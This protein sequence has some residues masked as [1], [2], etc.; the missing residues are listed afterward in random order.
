MGWPS[1]EDASG[2]RSSDGLW[3][4]LVFFFLKEI[5]G[6][7]E[8]EA[9]VFREQ[10]FLFVGEEQDIGAL[11][12]LFEFLYPAGEL[13]DVLNPGRTALLILG[14]L[15]IEV[16]ELV[17]SSP[18]VGL[19]HRAVLIATAFLKRITHVILNLTDLDIVAPRL[20]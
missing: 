12:K 18:D 3:G 17:A 16:A 19:R 6:L 4:R 10:A 15:D 5:G 14:P 11:Q 2:W 9:G 20:D 13:I 1:H 7:A 8:S